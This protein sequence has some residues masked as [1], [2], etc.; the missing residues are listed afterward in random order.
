MKLLLPRNKEDSWYDPIHI[1]HSQF[2]ATLV[3]VLYE[4]LMKHFTWF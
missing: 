3:Y 4:V 2:L 1:F